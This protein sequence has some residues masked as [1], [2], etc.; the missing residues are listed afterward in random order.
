M[1]SYADTIKLHEAVGPVLRCK[2]EVPLPNPDGKGSQM[3]AIATGNEPRSANEAMCVRDPWV[4]NSP[5]Q[6]LLL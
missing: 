1:G 6:V 4:P 2:P 5:R 3:G